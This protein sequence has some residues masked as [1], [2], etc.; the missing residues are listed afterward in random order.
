V[1]IEVKRH[2]S[3]LVYADINMLGVRVH[4]VKKNTESLVVV[5]DEVGLKA[6]SGKLST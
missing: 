2:I 5:S 3:A 1:W 6:D 4:T